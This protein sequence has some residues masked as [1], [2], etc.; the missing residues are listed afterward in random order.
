M[1]HA[2][3]THPQYFADVKAGIKKFELRK[4]D[5]PFDM[6]DTL[7]LMEW[8]P[9]SLNYTG[10]AMELRIIYILRD[11]PHFGLM[12]GYVILGMEEIETQ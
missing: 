11:A 1:T 5:R 9:E 3:K 7:L 6:G 2:L 10:N 12:E 8:N 4:D